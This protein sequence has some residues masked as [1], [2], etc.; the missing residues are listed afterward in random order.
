[1]AEIII[2][3]FYYISF[4]FSYIIELFAWVTYRFRLDIFENFEFYFANFLCL[5]FQTSI[6]NYLHFEYELLFV[7]GFFDIMFNTIKQ[8]L[9]LLFLD[10]RDR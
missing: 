4:I 5:F 9:I 3:Q 2:G 7:D 8:E 10:A 1:M 6:K